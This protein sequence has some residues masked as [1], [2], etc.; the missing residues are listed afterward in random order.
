MVDESKLQDFL[1]ELVV[2][3]EVGP[4]I[5][6]AI[7]VLPGETEQEFLEV[8]SMMILDITPQ[9][10]IEWLCAI[11]LACL[12]WE[13]QRY[14]CWKVAIIR[15]NRSAALVDA[16]YKSDPNYSLLG[17]Q[18]AIRAQ[19]KLD[20]EKWHNDPNRRCELNVRLTQH[21][22]DAKGINA[23]AFI[24]GLIPLATIE[25]FLASAR[26]QVNVLL[27][28]IGIRR[29][30]AQRARKAFER[31]ATAPTEEMELAAAATSREVKPI[32]VE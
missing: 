17:R 5:K 11:D 18:P 19:A 16:L 13:I 22:Y 25:R 30:F 6:E 9:N 21:G 14:R 7:L 20:A 4:F 8:M 23:E 26:S 28:E 27:R 3:E 29:E 31:L 10:Y 32:A 1:E 2:P 24:G 12:W 15:A